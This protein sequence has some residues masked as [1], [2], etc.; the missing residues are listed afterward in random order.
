MGGASAITH[1]I[2]LQVD[3]LWL[4]IVIPSRH[5]PQTLVLLEQRSKGREVGE[6]VG[7]HF[8]II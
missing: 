7:S 6:E 1:A 4:P 8:Q 3:V 5:T 2:A